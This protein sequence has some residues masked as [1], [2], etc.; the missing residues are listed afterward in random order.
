VGG[1]RQALVAK[2]RIRSHE[3]GIAVGGQINAGE[4]LVVQRVREGQR[5]GDDRIISVIA[6][7]GRTRHD[8][9]TDLRYRVVI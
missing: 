6:D 3:L 9:A 7:I 8:T 2:G 4:G 1:P 5:D